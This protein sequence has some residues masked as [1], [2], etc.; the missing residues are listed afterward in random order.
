MFL[1]KRDSF[2]FSTFLW[3]GFF[4]IDAKQFLFNWFALNAG[5][6]LFQNPRRLVLRH[7]NCPASEFQMP[8]LSSKLTNFRLQFASDLFVRNFRIY[9]TRKTLSSV[10]KIFELIGLTYWLLMRAKLKDGMLLIWR[11]YFG[12]LIFPLALRWFHLPLLGEFSRQHLNREFFFKILPSLSIPTPKRYLKTWNEK[13]KWTEC[14]SRFNL[15]KKN[16]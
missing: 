10:E 1:Q 4:I 7:N 16:T 13:M 5:A 14:F 6:F 11:Y 3:R 2:P 12:W 9:G 15:T 8:A